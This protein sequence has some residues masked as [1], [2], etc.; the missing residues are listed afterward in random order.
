MEENKFKYASKENQ[1]QRMNRA[2]M[3]STW[4]YVSMILIMDLV[5]MLHG[6]TQ[7]VQFVALLICALFFEVVI[8]VM[9]KR[10]SSS[11]R[12]KI[13]L[14]V[15]FLCNF[16]ISSY[17]SAS[18]MSLLLLA[19]IVGTL[20]LYD[21]K[22]TFIASVVVG[23][24][25]IL[26]VILSAVMKWGGMS[27]RIFFMAGYLFFL[28]IAVLSA[29]IGEDFQRD[30]FAE[31]D[32]EKSEQKKMLAD[33]LHVASEVRKGTGNAMD[34]V[35]SLS[36]STGTV[37]DAVRDIA[38]S[39][40]ST[41]ENIQ[42]QSV[43]T[44]KIQ[45]SIDSTLARSEEM[46][47]IAKKAGEINGHS[48]EIMNHLH[49]QAGTISESNNNAAEMMQ[50]LREKAESVKG[51]SDTILS[52]SNQ[53]NLLAL[54]A[55]IESAR[56]GEA[57]R[58]FA[59]VADEIREL[60][61]KT[62]SETESIAAVLEELSEQADSAGAA[63]TAS[64][65]A[66]NQQIEMIQEASDSFAEMNEN[67]TQLGSNIEEID[68]MISDLS[69]ANNQIVDNITQLSAATEEVT[70]SSSQAENLSADN[71]TNADNTKNL[72]SG[73]M[74]VSGELDKYLAGMQEGEASEESE[75]QL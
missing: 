70:A 66:T 67:V 9:Y 6:M 65:E 21:R 32:Y 57:G 17:V 37:T 45:D 69:E 34:V 22:F 10:N 25:Q 16:G 27:D 63:V 49:T 12:I 52:I 47:K 23:L 54:N 24:A 68:H 40:Q 41:A 73:V 2:M 62:R 19:P 42:Q 56:A 15:M 8:T 26:F 46:V 7:P 33:V 28:M 36:E 30:T 71:L 59:V 1:Y 38:G 5:A 48:M 51:I 43:M 35:N 72:L 74:D 20:F 4:M 3:I 29:N 61:E 53:T 39:T 64:V 58:G 18:P 31:M 44:Q 14:F 60:A 50:V 55:S 13:V 75:E 11:K